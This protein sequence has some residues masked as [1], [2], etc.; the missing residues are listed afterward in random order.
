MH[1]HK[2]HSQ[3]LGSWIAGRAIKKVIM[4]APNALSPAFEHVGYQAI[5][6]ISY[7]RSSAMGVAPD[8]R[9]GAENAA[10]SDH[11]TTLVT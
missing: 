11:Q 1:D 5:N 6:E 7:K 4:G 2:R 9:R 3:G 10:T 8:T